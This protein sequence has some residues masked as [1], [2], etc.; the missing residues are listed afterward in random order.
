MNPTQA[1]ELARQDMMALLIEGFVD[2]YRRY[3]WQPPRR[4]A[5]LPEQDD[6]WGIFGFGP[7]DNRPYYVV[8]VT[9]KRVNGVVE[10]VSEVEIFNRPDY[11]R[12]TIWDRLS[13]SDTPP[14]SE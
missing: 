8:K 9:G 5:E 11:A 2:S 3:V 13:A 7:S 1:I 4:S 10:M 6:P 12:A 14:S